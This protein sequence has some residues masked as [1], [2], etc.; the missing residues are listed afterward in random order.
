MNAQALA[1]SRERLEA[2]I[3]G[4]IIFATTLTT[5]VGPLLLG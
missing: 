1:Q 3:A 2:L 4:A 5:V